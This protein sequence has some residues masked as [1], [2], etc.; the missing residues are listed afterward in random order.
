MPIKQMF[1]NETINSNFPRKI[2]FQQNKYFFWPEFVKHKLK[3]GY[4]VNYYT[5]FSFATEIR[6]KSSRLENDKGKEKF[7]GCICNSQISVFGTLSNMQDC[8]T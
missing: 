1:I 7:L 4:F 6:L 8:I 5:P 3:I 2:D